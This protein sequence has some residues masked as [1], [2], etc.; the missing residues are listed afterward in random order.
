MNSR[1]EE[2]Q[3]NLMGKRFMLRT[4]NLSEYMYAGMEFIFG[5]PYN[6]REA[7]V[8]WSDNKGNVQYADYYIIDIF[9]HIKDGSW[10]VMKRELITEKL[11]IEFRVNI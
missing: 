11:K 9:E 4:S 2:Y 5:K 3:N 10:K 8:Y 6:N 7:V 1:V